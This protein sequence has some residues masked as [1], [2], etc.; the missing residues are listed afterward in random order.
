MRNILDTSLLLCET[1]RALAISISQNILLNRLSEVIPILTTAVPPSLVIAAGA[2]GLKQIVSSAH[3]LRQLRLAYA[4]AIHSTLLF[5]LGL[6]C[7]A[8]PFAWGMEWLNIKDIAEE[9][10]KV[11]GNSDGMKE[12]TAR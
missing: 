6:A 4:E 8:F 11:A 9:R 5:A 7:A 10:K 12:A 3:D 2:T 1:F